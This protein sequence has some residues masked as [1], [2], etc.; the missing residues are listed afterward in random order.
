MFSV[1]VIES[2]IAT[3]FVHTFSCVGVDS[4]VGIIISTVGLQ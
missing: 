3:K 1:L 4:C 2:I